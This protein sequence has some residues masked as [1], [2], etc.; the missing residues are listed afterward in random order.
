MN[1]PEPRSSR[2][3]AAARLLRRQAATA[4]ARPVRR[5]LAL[6]VLCLALLIVVLDTTVLNVALPWDK[7]RRLRFLRGWA[8]T[9]W[10]PSALAQ[11]AVGATKGA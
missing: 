7:V 6:G 11:P 9:P 8:K 2:P 5:G 4:P 3:G 1:A 10:G